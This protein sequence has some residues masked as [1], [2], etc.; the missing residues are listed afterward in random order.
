[1][2]IPIKVIELL[3]FYQLSAGMAEWSKHSKKKKKR[4]NNIVMGICKVCC[5]CTW[6]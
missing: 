5:V 1:L 3:L 2:F 6:L 4:N